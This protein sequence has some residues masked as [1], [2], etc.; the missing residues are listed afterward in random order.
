MKNDSATTYVGIDV[1]DRQSEVCV[2]DAKGEVVE[3][4]RFATS[5]QGLERCFARR[6]P[7]AV[8]LE[9]GP[10]S[11][12]MART[13]TQLG[14]D[15]VVANARRVRLIAKNKRKNDR[16]DAMLLARLLRADRQLLYPVAHRGEAAQRDLAVL[17]QRDALVRARTTLVTSVRGTV[18]AYGERLP[19]CDT[20]SFARHARRRLSVEVLGC[21]ELLVAQIEALTTAIR[22]ADRQIVVACERHDATQRLRQIQGVGPITSLAFVV[23][24]ETPDRFPRQRSVGT[25]LGLTPAQSSS[26]DSDPQLSISREGDP[27]LRRLLVQSAQYILGPFGPDCDLRRFGMRLYQRG[28]KAAKRRAVVAVARKLSILLLRLWRTGET[29]V[30]LREATAIAVPA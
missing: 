29:Y 27:F 22:V 11:R 23:S 7:S 9:V 26:G 14:H 25:F 12:W 1:S 17:R 2:L 16:A 28:G 21:V 10:H 4:T 20:E 6:P 5:R 24:L 3:T 18:K 19:K 8:C 13:L 30:P 15:V